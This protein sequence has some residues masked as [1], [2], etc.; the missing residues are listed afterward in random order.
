MAFILAY[1]LMFQPLR[2]RLG[3]TI[4]IATIAYL[5]TFAIDYTY[6]TTSSLTAGGTLLY[7]I[8]EILI[9]QGTAFLVS[10]YRDFRT[11]FTGFCAAAYVMIGNIAYAYALNLS[12]GIP[13][14][15][16][17]QTAIHT[18]LLA[19][20]IVRMRSSYLE[21][22]E[23]TTIPWGFMCVIP[24][25]FYAALY[26]L[27]LFTPEGSAA[28]IV[29]SAVILLLMV[30]TF[31]L[32]Y[33]FI[34]RMRHDNE[35]MQNNEILEAYAQC[36]EHEASIFET[37]EARTAILRHD[38]RH[39]GTLILAYLD[40]GET[41]KVRALVNETSIEIDQ[42]APVKYCDNIA[43]NGILSHYAQHA[44]DNAV[45][46]S[47]SVNLPAQLAVD[48]FEYATVMLNL[49]ENALDSAKEV[50]DPDKRA[51]RLKVTRS[52]GQSLLEVSNT[53]EGERQFSAETGLPISRRGAGHGLGLRS[54]Q[55][56]AKRHD[57][58]FD[59]SA[60]NGVFYVR[61]LV[62]I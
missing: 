61:L 14:A 52:K 23:N 31:I 20:F 59:Y 47:C 28:A 15:L 41:D 10:A 17:V 53:Y 34:S 43:V 39:K 37:A 62:N 56:F 4:A 55:T 22:L 46:F 58:L 38:M 18:A 7:T 51:V 40:A 9:V 12:A 11:L 44:H 33:E 30:A 26:F 6:F 32:V 48:E 24:A 45:A 54:V 2:Y 27:F 5:V 57:A 13:L 60:E 25:C 3:K 42:S 21:T 8:V 36:L 49:L 29:P 19:Y 35:L 50:K 16:V 1:I